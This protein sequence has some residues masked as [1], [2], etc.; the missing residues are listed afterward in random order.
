MGIYV[1]CDVQEQDD[2]L[3]NV[4][5]EFFKT[6]DIE[7]AN[8][9]D[10][11]DCLGDKLVISHTI[12]PKLKKYKMYKIEKIYLYYCGVIVSAWDEERLIGLRQE[13]VNNENWMRAKGINDLLIDIN[14]IKRNIAVSSMP[15]YLQIETTSYCNAK[16]IMCSH[17]FSE[18]KGASNLENITL[19]HLEDAIQLS[20]VISLNGMGEPFIS[21]RVSDQ[22]DYYS[23][24]GNKIVTNTNLSV[25]TDRLIDQINNNFEWLE[26]SCDGATKETY[27]AIRQNLN[28]EVFLHNLFI[29]KEKCPN[30]RK[31][32]AAVVMRQNVCEMPDL[33]KLASQAGASI[34]TFMTLNSNI[35]IQNQQDE[36]YHYP[37]VLEYYSVQALKAGE[38]Y[39]IPV[40]LPN[41]DNLNKEITVEEISDELYEMKQIPF[42]KSKQK[43][44]KMKKTAS[45]VLKYLESHD[46]IQRETKASNI[47]CYGIC[48]WLL[49]RSYID[50]Q[51]NV[52]MCCRNQ[53]FHTGNVNESG[54][55]SVVWNSSFYQRLREIFYSG[56]VPES[57]LKCGLIESGN[58]RFLS[59]E[60][61]EQFYQEPQYKIRQKQTLN[62][63]LDGENEE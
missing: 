16:C 62:A 29:L 13:A 15:D 7:F 1:V 30:V 37:K 59:V 63:L 9:Y 19:K 52:A 14:F 61:K 40:I 34:I 2:T 5:R 31:H 38:K 46:E 56:Y 35:I 27:E 39:G 49:K 41:R 53:S 45:V 57:C 22:I 28:Y 6:E 47:R 32:I 25:L 21:E 10:Y 58:L 54:S 42:F 12:I 36:M 20:R 43:I 51:G 17:Y 26:V 44:D 18:N 60:M 55:F 3:R 48:D 8:S 24:L 11:E 33:V 23:S 50:L 4:V